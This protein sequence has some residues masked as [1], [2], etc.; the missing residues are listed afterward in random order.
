M[1]DQKICFFIFAKSSSYYAR[2]ICKA[3]RSQ[4]LFSFKK[5]IVIDCVLIMIQDINLVV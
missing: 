2:L 1:F 3:P 4:D 5:K